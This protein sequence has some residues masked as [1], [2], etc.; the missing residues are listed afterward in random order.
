MN[1][2]IIAIGTE[3]LTP[4]RQDTN[5][6][7]LTEELNALGVVVRFKTIVG[8]RRQDL[9]RAIRSAIARTDI[10]IV[11]GGLGPTEDDLSREAVAEALGLSL[12][13]D[14]SLVAALRDL[15]RTQI[16]LDASW[17]ELIRAEGRGREVD[18]AMGVG[19]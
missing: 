8:D 1:C 13:R 2:E 10:V 6:L 5:S 15:Y 18:L 16:E 19:G 17:V 3:M 9:L 7:F 12:R 11:M 14:G 4:W